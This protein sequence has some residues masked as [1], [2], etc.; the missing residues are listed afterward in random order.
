MQEKALYLAA[1]F[2]E[3]TQSVF[4]ELYGILQ[5][6][7]FVGTQTKNLSYHITLGSR[8][9]EFENQTVRDLEIICA[10]TRCFDINLAHIGL[11]G[12]NV[13][14][15]SPNMNYELLNLERKFFPDCCNGYHP[16]SAHATLLIDEPNTVY[17]ALPIVA[18]HFKPFKAR[19][20]SVELYEF[21][22]A[23]EITSSKLLSA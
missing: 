8:G 5:R 17:N 11:F 1:I 23:R 20:E 13:L 22:P 14:F 16:W 19:I 2:D 4:A 10:E 18:E 7:G 6:N 12:L 9:V 3:R 21:F 15:I